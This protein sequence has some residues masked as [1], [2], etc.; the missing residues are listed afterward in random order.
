[1][2]LFW[3]FSSNYTKAK[4]V[5]FSLVLLVI[6]L[7]RLPAATSGGRFFLFPP[8]CV[9]L[10]RRSKITTCHVPEFSLSTLF[11]VSNWIFL[12]HIFAFNARQRAVPPAACRG[13]CFL[14]SARSAR[15]SPTS[16]RLL[17]RVTASS[18]DAAPFIFHRRQT[19]SRRELNSRLSAAIT[20]WFLGGEYIDF[21]ISPL[22]ESV[23]AVAGKKHLCR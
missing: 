8:L 10:K 12:S 13:R 2:W 3:R 5:Y 4:Y 23:S 21:C 19:F 14:P 11:F 16:S 1:M 17:S 22:S 15:Q 7:H 18:S 20:L 9:I 6:S